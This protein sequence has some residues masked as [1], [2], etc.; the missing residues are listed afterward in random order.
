VTFDGGGVPLQKKKIILF[1]ALNLVFGQIGYTELEFHGFES[2]LPS[3]GPWKGNMRHKVEIF[4]SL[5]S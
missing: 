1:F 2:T 4:F 5:F 3:R